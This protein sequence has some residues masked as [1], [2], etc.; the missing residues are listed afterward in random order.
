MKPREN[1]NLKEGIVSLAHQSFHPSSCIPTFHPTCLT[2]V[3]QLQMFTHELCSLDTPVLYLRTVN[4]VCYVIET[5][6]SH[7]QIL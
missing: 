2:F 1:F 5:R 7:A 4:L 6:S 3:D